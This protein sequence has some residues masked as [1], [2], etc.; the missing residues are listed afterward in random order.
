MRFGKTRNFEGPKK[1][2]LRIKTFRLKNNLRRLR[3]KS[4]V[5]TYTETHP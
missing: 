5:V 4:Y 2:V 1:F 3:A